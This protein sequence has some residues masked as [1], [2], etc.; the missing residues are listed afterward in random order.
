[1]QRSNP[2][3]GY[4]FAVLNMLISG[5]AIYVNSLGVRLF[6][7]STLYT[8]L[9]NA[10]VGV[11]LIIPVLVS[12][13]RRREYTRLK[14]R[15]WVLLVLVSLIGGSV[16]YAL[17]FYGLKI[18]TP[19]TAAV[20]GHTQF[21]LVGVLAAIFL[22][23]RFGSGVWAALVVLLIGLLVGIRLDT[24]KWDAGAPFVVA[25]TALFATDFVLMKYLL[26][27]V[28][29]FVVMAFKM[30]LGAVFLLVYVAAT[31]HLALF[32][33]LS[34]LQW[35]FVTVT[36]LILLAFTVTSIFGLQ[37]ASAT[38]VTAIPAASPIVT[39]LLV[40]VSRSAT[41]APIKWLGFAF[42]LLAVLAIFILGR[43]QEMRRTTHADNP[44]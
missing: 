33:Q 15:E 11:A 44:R 26:R 23:E 1:M 3:L 12:R 19:V 6:S 8:F 37:H 35:G 9:K 29:S 21:L 34:T 39:T 18:T 2:R 42:M 16:A 36:G 43:R 20:I 27:S 13:E 30:T 10:I 7:D 4:A 25:S 22:G 31:G 5:V 24:V 14:R 40:V 32:A 28:S 41:I 38:A 17:F